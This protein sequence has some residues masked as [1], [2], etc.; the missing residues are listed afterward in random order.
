MKNYGISD[1]SLLGAYRKK[2]KI[3]KFSDLSQIYVYF[4]LWYII[5]VVRQD[6]LLI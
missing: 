4:T 5:C 3:L 1:T 2:K 6:D